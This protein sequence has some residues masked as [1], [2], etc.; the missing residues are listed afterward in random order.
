M[1]VPNDVTG[2]SSG[3]NN[4]Q[5]ISEAFK[6]PETVNLTE[7]IESSHQGHNRQHNDGKLTFLGSLLGLLVKLSN[8][9]AG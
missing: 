8:G 3:G 1:D 7:K 4:S 5:A 6:T 9:I 2:E